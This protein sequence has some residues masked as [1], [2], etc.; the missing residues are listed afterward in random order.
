MRSRA[1]ESLLKDIKGRR[2]CEEWSREQARGSQK[3]EELRRRALSHPMS[4]AEENILPQIVAAHSLTKK[5][6]MT[7]H[8]ILP[9][10][11]LWRRQSSR[12]RLVLHRKVGEWRTCTS[13][14]GETG[15]RHNILV[16]TRVPL[17]QAEDFAILNKSH[18]Y[19]H[20][21]CAHPP[22]HVV[23][24]RRP[25]AQVGLKPAGDRQGSDHFD[26]SYAREH[27]DVPNA[28]VYVSRAGWRNVMR[29]TGWAV[30]T[31]RLLPEGDS[32]LSP[33]SREKEAPPVE[34]ERI[35]PG[36][37]PWW[38]ES[39]IGDDPFVFGPASLFFPGPRR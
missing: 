1:R 20:E 37:I 24:P 15:G 39:S 8:A 2:L 6:E 5:K 13:T 23:E 27:R 28:D 30:R 9:G 12:V 3:L 10:R 17:K 4:V 22:E 35:V 29:A 36:W 19:V 26:P 11:P 14:T 33:R 16:D 7:T 34:D 21:A 31:P 18:Q 38:T 32:R 25:L